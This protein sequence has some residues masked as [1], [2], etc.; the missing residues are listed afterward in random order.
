MP[1]IRTGPDGRPDVQT[2]PAPGSLSDPKGKEGAIYASY[3]PVNVFRGPRRP[4]FRRASGGRRPRTTP[5]F[6]GVLQG[7]PDEP[8]GGG[9]GGLRRVQNA[10]EPAYRPVN[11]YTGS[12]FH[13]FTGSRVEGY[14]VMECAFSVFVFGSFPASGREGPGAGRT[15]P[16]DR[17]PDGSSRC[18]DWG[19]RAWVGPGSLP[20]EPGVR[21]E[22]QTPSCAFLQGPG[23]T[24]GPPPDRVPDVDRT[25]DRESPGPA[26]GPADWANPTTASSA[27]RASRS[28]SAWAVATKTC[29]LGVHHSVGL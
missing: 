29:T 20:A 28:H 4:S 11:R 24:P 3:A 26:S 25:V 19:V 14:R 18:R 13:G 27:S 8:A 10:Q 6:S 21:N 2:G 5:R 9:P 22:G 17:G 23:R 1:P 16:E 12:L 7:R 15:S